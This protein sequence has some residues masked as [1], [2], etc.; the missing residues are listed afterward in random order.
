MNMKGK[1]CL[2]N[3][4]KIPRNSIQL[5]MGF[6]GLQLSTR[7]NNLR[8]APWHSRANFLPD[9]VQFHP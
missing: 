3:W 6:D 4:G 5:H 8:E 1:Y 9:Y 7:M 2:G